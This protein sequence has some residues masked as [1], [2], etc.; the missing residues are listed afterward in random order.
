M[1]TGG[2]LRRRNCRTK[3]YRDRL[4]QLPEAIV[5]LAERAFEVFLRDPLA[6]ALHNH[7]LEDSGKGQHRS[8]SRSVYVNLRYRAIYVVD[9]NVNVWYWIGSHEDY[10]NFTGAK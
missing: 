5:K 4:N 10:N 9:D 8:G 6:P 1:S 2:N 3:S 7:E